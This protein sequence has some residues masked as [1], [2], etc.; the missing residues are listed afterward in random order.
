MLAVHVRS[1]LAR[2]VRARRL[3]AGTLALLAALTVWSRAAALDH[4]RRAWGD[5]R[6][7]WLAD[8][9]TAGDPVVGRPVLAPLALVPAGAVTVDPTGMPAHRRVPAG[10]IVTEHDLRRGS[11]LPGAG[12]RGV[13]VPADDTTLQASPGDVVDVV[14]DGDVV[15]RD[16][17]VM[18][19]SP[20]AVLVAVDAAD[21]A[22]VAAAAIERRAALVLVSSP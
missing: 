8:D 10:A 17:E 13:S 16:G 18:R 3:L 21:A 4:E 7:V 6:T 22:A 15:A 2:H 9:T 14:S 11:S 19:T 20:T 5:T 12:R 1:F